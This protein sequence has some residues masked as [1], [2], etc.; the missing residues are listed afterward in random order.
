MTTGF[1]V[2]MFNTQQTVNNNNIYAHKARLW[3]IKCSVGYI[4]DSR[5]CRNGKILTVSEWLMRTTDWRTE[6]WRTNR[7]THIRYLCGCYKQEYYLA[8]YWIIYNCHIWIFVHL[9]GI[10]RNQESKLDSQIHLC[11]ASN[12]SFSDVHQDVVEVPGH[13]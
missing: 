2:S 4:C 5:R 3:K 6:L 8:V 13:Y 10:V 12:Y 1:S 11:T 7:P 9:P